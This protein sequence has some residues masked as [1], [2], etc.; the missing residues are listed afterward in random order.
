MDLLKALLGGGG[1]ALTAAEAKTRLESDAP[2]F[3]LDVRQPEEFRAARI[4]G[5]TL[6]PLDELPERLGELPQD[7]D[8]LCVCQSGARSSAAVRHLTGA[9]YRALNLRGGMVGWQASGLP[10]KK[11]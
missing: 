3:L 1:N 8:V 5:A 11:G 6:I 7:R 9:G 10:V 2:P 4:A